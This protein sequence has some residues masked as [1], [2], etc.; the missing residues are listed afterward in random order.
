M[1]L[2]DVAPL[3]N[4][5]PEIGL[6]VSSMQDST[7]EWRENLGDVA[8]EAMTWQCYENGPSI[9]GLLMHLIDCE[10]GWITRAIMQMPEDNSSEFNRYNMDLDVDKPFWPTPP[11]H[12]L[13][14]YLATH[15]QVRAQMI[16]LLATVSDPDRI[17]TRGENGFTPRW[18]LTHLIQHDSYTGGQAVLLHEIWKKRT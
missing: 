8:D 2:Y 6:L 17:I 10:Y 16:Q 7:R 15:D 9:G 1:N 5:N 11:A 12:P 3:E 13:S 18:V 14:W 4:F